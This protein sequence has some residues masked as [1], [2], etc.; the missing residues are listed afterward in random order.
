[1]TD[2]R[3]RISQSAR[4]GTR[5]LL[6][7]LGLLLAL[8]T[9]SC[10]N[11]VF[12]P[13]TPV[14][15]ITDRSGA[16]TSYIVTLYS[17][18]MT[19]TDGT[20]VTLPMINQQVDLVELSNFIEVMAAPAAQVGTYT[21]M[22][23]TLEYTGAQIT[24][25]VNGHS[26]A[27]NVLDPTTSPANQAAGTQTLTVQFDPNNPLVISNQK[28]TLVN[29]DMDLAAGS[30]IDYSTT[31][32]PTVYIKS[33]AT[34]NATPVY[35]KPVRARGLFVIADTK[36]NNFIM[37]VRPF[38]DVSNNPFGAMTIE[39][40]DQTYYNINGVSY[41]GSAGLAALAA[42]QNT[43]SN[44]QVQVYGNGPGAGTPFSSLSTI[45]PSFVPT[46]VYA[47]TSVEST[48]QDHVVGVVGGISGNTVNV[49]GA[50]FIWRFGG[51]SAYGTGIAFYDT[52]PVTV[53]S[54]TTVSQDGV[55]TSLN[56]SSLSV[57]QAIDVSG[58]GLDA[59][60][61]AI[62]LLSN[63]NL[64]HLDASAGAAYANGGQFRMQ[65]TS[66]W[67]TVVST[68]PT[69]SCNGMTMNLQLLGNFQPSSFSFTGTQTGGGATSPAT[70]CVNTGSLD[71]SSITAA[72]ANSAQ[73]L[74]RVD[75]FV[76]PFGA[77]P[78]DFNATAVTLGTATTDQQL[79]LEW[80]AGT[81]TPFTSLAATGLVPDLSPSVLTGLHEIR[82]GPN[83]QD[84]TLL[85]AG[86]TI[87]PTTVASNALV[88]AVGNV[89]NNIGSFS[90]P[91]PWV[92][93]INTALGKG[94]A[95]T[96]L[97]AT[98]SYDP[99]TNTFNAYDISINE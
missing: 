8:L 51:N 76:A 77:A 31:P 88:L 57:G 12:V 23:L 71:L 86:F 85:P 42:I 79:I 93:A 3:A 7:G 61:N 9:A 59:N 16:F 49:L 48:I 72:T 80:V 97:V 73:P 41:T 52:F 89:A 14:V 11:N 36:N 94:T 6:C 45:T 27:A 78:P 58:Q 17:I 56:L 65:S 22:T 70:Y 74:V 55:N 24:V 44:F 82:T 43:Y 54:T 33:F 2:V 68:T 32:N 39:P 26:V 28:S 67:G 75:G 18:Q 96:K 91:Q 63:A 90:S 95:V 50:E 99:A 40:T 62:T 15:T 1:M 30:R 84:V 34:V 37:N 69:G 5:Y 87:A 25:D 98:G 46:A 10:G 47:G 92:T 60:G 21:S 64:T 66:A 83:S 29:I 38:H 35:N 19:A 20:V 53:S 4:T 13:G 81:T